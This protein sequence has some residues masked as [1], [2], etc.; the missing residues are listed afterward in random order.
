MNQKTLFALWGGLYAVCAALGFVNT[1]STAAQ[2]LMTLLAIIFFAPAALLL[3]LSRT[4]GDLSIAVLIRNF[5]LAS[6]I[7][8]TVLL[9][10]NFL[11]VL[12]P[13]LLGNILYGILVI[14][15]A[16]M[17]CCGNWALSMFL[18]AC[19]LICSLKIL[20]ARKNP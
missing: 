9:I 12:A 7:L 18:W 19:L 17:I 3:Q 2:V 14:V 6:L 15:S 5:S 20:K 10:A 11:S 1:Q 4:G 13:E 8:T 16:P